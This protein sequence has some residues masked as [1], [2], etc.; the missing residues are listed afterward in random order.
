MMNDES[1]QGPRSSYEYNYRSTKVQHAQ[2]DLAPPLSSLGMMA[3]SQ[4]FEIST[5]QKSHPL[6]K[7]PPFVHGSTWVGMDWSLTKSASFQVPFAVEHQF[8]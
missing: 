2:H 1:S 6:I 8:S 4:G 5:I 7:I 3:C